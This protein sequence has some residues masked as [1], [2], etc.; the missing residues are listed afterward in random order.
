M[1]L[2][3]FFLFLLKL[4]LRNQGPEAVTPGNRS[5]AQRLRLPVSSV[6]KLRR[7]WWNRTTKNQFIE[8][9]FYFPDGIRTLTIRWA[10]TALTTELPRNWRR[11]LVVLRQAKCPVPQ[12]LCFTL[13]VEE[14]TKRFFAPLCVFIL[15][16]F[17][18]SWVKFPR[19]VSS[20]P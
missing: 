17:R 12:C 5:L 8:N 16:M 1:L 15:G 3:S 19:L 2:S 10:S 18:P 9:R 20:A 13:P 4:F 14:T 11:C 7:V 6:G